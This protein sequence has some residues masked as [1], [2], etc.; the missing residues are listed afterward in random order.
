MKHDDR[1]L[2]PVAPGKLADLDIIGSVHRRTSAACATSSLTV[3]KMAKVAT[4]RAVA[5][6]IRVR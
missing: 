3:I 1:V 6:E 4:T 5:A 2:D